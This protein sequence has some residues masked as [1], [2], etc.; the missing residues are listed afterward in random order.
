MEINFIFVNEYYFL[1]ER[2]EIFLII[3][4]IYIIIVKL[5]KDNFYFD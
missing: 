1:I 2:K 3:V 5:K 4:K